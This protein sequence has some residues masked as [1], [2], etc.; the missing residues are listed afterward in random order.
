MEGKETGISGNTG[1]NSAQIG[2]IG[3]GMIGYAFMGGRIPMH[4][5]R[6]PI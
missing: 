5:K 3:I 4:I 6:S 2:E 1:T